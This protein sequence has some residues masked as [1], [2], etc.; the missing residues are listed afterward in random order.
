MRGNLTPYRFVGTFKTVLFLLAIGILLGIVVY[1]EQMMRQ[2]RE[3]SRRYLTLKVER[4]RELLTRGEDE[5]LD[6]YL[7]EMATRDFPLIVADAQHNPISWSGISSLE[8]LPL[9]DAQR[10]AQRMMKIWMRQGNRPVEVN[11]SEFGLTL[12]FYYGDSPVVSKL[13]VLPWI[14][15][16]LAGGLIL[17]GYFG[18]ITIK[19]GE[20][21]AVWVGLARETAHQMG[22]PLTALLGWHQILKENEGTRKLA[23]ELERDLERMKVVVERFQQ[24]G[25]E[26]Q[27]V[28][29]TL[30]PWIERAVEYLQSR[31]PVVLGNRIDI[32]MQIPPELGAKIS[33]ILFE[34][35]LENII[36][37]AAEA[38]KGKEGKI[39]IRAK[40]EKKKVIIEVED[41]GVGIPRRRWREVFRS[42]YSTKERG[43]GLGLSLAKRI[44]EDFHRGRIE[45]AE[46]EPLRGTVMRITLPQ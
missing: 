38:M 30:N 37:N 43:W 31:L 13:R 18:F 34:W 25:S 24:I 4:Y 36:R 42:G 17:I 41:E 9:P 8:N 7:R 45:V 20:E 1:N 10:E 29:T 28:R 23:E 27:L 16:F 22:T 5:A 32:Q 14:E 6:H 40:A 21:R 44:I 39:L 35:V 12:F 46:S 2:L 19:R 3:L 26:P 11:L 33:P 15:A